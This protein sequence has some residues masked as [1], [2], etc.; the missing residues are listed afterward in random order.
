MS[1]IWALGDYE[2]VAQRFAP[3][4]ERLMDALSP[5][6]GMRWLD[7]ATGTGEIALRAARA[8]ARVTAL[9][10]NDEL[11]QQARAKAHD[12]QLPIDF[13]LGDAQSLPFDDEAFDVVSSCFGIIFP[14]DRDAVAHEL[15]RVTRPG[16]RL[17][18]T[19]WSPREDQL[20]LYRRFAPPDVEPPPDHTDWGR[21]G[22]AAALLGD[23]F[24]LQIDEGIW[25]LEDE[26][27][28]TLYDFMT[29]NAPPGVAF[30]ERLAP[31]RRDEYREAQIA[32]WQRF[33][34][35]S[36]RVSEP[37]RYVLVR[38]TRR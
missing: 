4:H 9:D 29:T 7:V 10:F 22:F 5:A 14:P 27:P 21:D 35:A 16:G 25:R 8:G 24:D 18:L 15:A 33:A 28:G 36:G 34:D 2:Q 11:L 38:G 1:E 6:A 30:L 23:A 20:E 13:V 37:W 17:G 32:Y 26:S 19:A 12:E 3:I 31:E